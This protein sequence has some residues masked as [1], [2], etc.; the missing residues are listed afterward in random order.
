MRNWMSPPE[1]FEE[2]NRIQFIN[3]N[4]MSVVQFYSGP[5]KFTLEWLDSMDKMVRQHV[6][7]QGMPMKRGMATCLSI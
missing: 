5:V 7:K 2:R 4:V 1:V 6:T 3:Q